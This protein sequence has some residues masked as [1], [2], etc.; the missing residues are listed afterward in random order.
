MEL[1]KKN[2]DFRQD[3][4][5][6]QRRVSNVVVRHHYRY[7]CKLTSGSIDIKILRSVLRSFLCFNK[8]TP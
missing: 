8:T 2:N 7:S 6:N 5:I 1:F 3:Y 4:K